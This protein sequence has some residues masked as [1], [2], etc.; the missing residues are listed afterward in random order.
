M[1]R[2]PRFLSVSKTANAVFG[3]LQALTTTGGFFAWLTMNI[4]FLR[5]YYGAKAQ[6][7]DRTKSAYYNRLQPWLSY[8]GV[9]WIIIFILTTGFYCF[10]PGQFTA[11]S[12]LTSYLCIP[13]FGALYFGYKIWRRTRFWKSSE[14]DFWTGIP[15][16]EET[17]GSY[18]PPTTRWG[19]IVDKVI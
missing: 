18:I 1:L 10:F 4:T 17:E 16:Y 7:I 5:F 9:F 14:M 2:F 3:W 13:I 6:G 15:S 19:K 12:F 8:W 11:A